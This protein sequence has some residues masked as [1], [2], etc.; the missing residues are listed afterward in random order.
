MSDI[1][2][3][4]CSICGCPG[5]FT[6]PYDGASLRSARCELCGSQR[7]HRDV[8]RVLLREVI[9]ADTQPLTQCLDKFANIKIMEFQSSGVLHTILRSLPFYRCSEYFDD[10][11]PG[12]RNIH[13]VECQDLYRLTLPRNFFDIVITQ[14]IFE[15]TPD[16][17]AA[18]LELHKIIKPGGKHIF[19]VPVHEAINT[20][21]RARLA[22]D[23]NILCAMPPVYHGDPLRSDGA[24]V[25]T[26]FGREL[27]ERLTRLG[28][29]TTKVL[30][31]KF[32]NTAEIANIDGEEKYKLYIASKE[33]NLTTFLYNSIVF[34]SEQIRNEQKQNLYR[35]QFDIS[36]DEF[37]IHKSEA[38]LEQLMGDFSILSVRGE[39]TRLRGCT[40]MML[41]ITLG[42]TNLP[43]AVLLMVQACW[44]DAPLFIFPECFK[45]N[46][47]L[48]EK[49][50]AQLFRVLQKAFSGHGL[51][52]DFLIDH[53][54]K[55]IADQ[56]VAERLVPGLAHYYTLIPHLRRYAFISAN[57]GTLRSVLD[58][59]CGVGYGLGLLNP[60]KGTGLDISSEALRW[61]KRVIRSPKLSWIQADIQTGPSPGLHDTIVCFENIEHLDDQT[62]LM[63]LLT[64]SV[65]PDGAVFVSVPNPS[66]RG[67]ESNHFHLRDFSFHQVSA[68]FSEYF[69]EIQW[70][71]QHD[72]ASSDFSSRFLIHDGAN[73]DADFWIL[74]CSKPKVKKRL[75]LRAS[76]I[77]VA[78]DHP[79]TAKKTVSALQINTPRR[80]TWEVILIAGPSA[81]KLIPE[82]EQAPNIRLVSCNTAPVD[83]Y[84][85]WNQGATVS[86]AEFLI[87]LDNSVV[88][89]PGWMDALLDELETQQETGLVGAKTIRI[90]GS[91]CN[92]GLAIGRN[93][94]PVDINPGLGADSPITNERRVCSA[95]SDQCIAVRRREFLRI[96]PFDE[97]LSTLAA[98][99]LCLRYKSKKKSIVYNPSCSVQQTKVKKD[100][101][102]GKD[103]FSRVFHRNMDQLI[104]D[105]F[106]HT[107]RTARSKLSSTPLRF[108]INI[109]TPSRA[110]NN[111]GDIYYAEC[112]AKYIVRGGHECIVQYQNEWHRE[113][114]NIDVTIHLKGLEK[115]Y[116]KPWHINIM[117]ML[118]HPDL[119][120][121]RELERYDALFV[122]S[123]SHTRI[124]ENTLAIP[125]FPLLQATDPE[126]FSPIAGTAKEYDLVFVGN[127]HGV[128]R[129]A[130]RKIIADLLPTTHRLAVW[131]QGWDGLLPA[132]CWKGEFLA[133]EQLPDIYRRS[134]IV[135][136]DHQPEMAKNGFL[137]N[138]TFDAL[139]CGALVIS[140]P[141][142]GMSEHIDVPQCGDAA[143]LK[144]TIDYFLKNAHAAQTLTASLREKVLT[145][146][147][148]E[149]AFDKIETTINIL[150]TNPSI[151]GRLEKAK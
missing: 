57:S 47:W 141:V 49:I 143:S 113:N 108:A 84:T 13:G 120:T 133:W 32:Y 79:E 88:V 21:T 2:E 4:K 144:S 67:K 94:A 86:R 139:A 132:D 104:Q 117:W 27:E 23:G 26:D 140:D 73:A 105:D 72:A 114:Y 71:W 75:P 34:V 46:L 148:F 146:H 12:G 66:S 65:K 134:C 87:F 15:H 41:D 8:A 82:L 102:V 11:A 150:L 29:P 19:T 109:C 85:A 99:D 130:M 10:I 74:R 37:Q 89:H 131:G 124:L 142:E 107:D 129:L 95:V 147:T 77:M 138:R 35:I 59:G 127:N 98:F 30:H 111:W 60:D 96:G 92:T 93:L 16:P 68:L 128:G 63:D 1:M 6:L 110:F 137:N 145:K 106:V 62:Q 43:S 103:K 24:L 31:A 119:H 9:G 25:F 20:R 64:T 118:N 121:K 54:G 48:I 91:V 97:Q 69:E 80:E 58:V 14:D 90:D 70:F 125:T 149:Y 100:D 44:G 42:N 56:Q 50:C 135:L 3:H 126:H 83:L 136:N 45:S 18:F 101:P 52:E 115:Y 39:K 7:R 151:Q 116:P 112:L 78:P 17:W 76:V 51:P 123:T 55:N 36:A 38:L 33:K 28:M 61:A 40:S 122:S 5:P 53:E 81:Q 22:P